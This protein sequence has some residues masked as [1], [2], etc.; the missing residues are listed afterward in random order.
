M[1]NNGRYAGYSSTGIRNGV[2]EYNPYI[3]I[4]GY[5]GNVSGGV[6]VALPY[7]IPPYYGGNGYPVAPYP[8]GYAPYFNYGYTQWG[9]YYIPRSLP[10]TVGHRPGCPA[11]AY[12]ADRIPGQMRAQKDYEQQAQAVIESATP[13]YEN[14]KKRNGFGSFLLGL[15]E[16]VFAIILFGGTAA[17]LYFTKDAAWFGY[18]IVILA[19]LIV[20]ISYTDH[21]KLFRLLSWG[22]AIVLCFSA[23]YIARPDLDINVLDSAKEAINALF[24]FF[25]LSVRI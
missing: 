18:A 8:Y 4:N 24:A 17:L 14:E 3:K 23:F 16:A 10:P 22:I 20:F 2:P 9:P 13:V 21:S 7:H 15:L 12:G 25:S 1:E 5:N 6:P 19:A 11:A